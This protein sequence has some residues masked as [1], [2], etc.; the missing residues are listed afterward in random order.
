[1]KHALPL[2]AFFLFGALFSACQSDPVAKIPAL[3][4]ILATTN[5]PGLADT[6]IQLY[7]A[8][9]KVHPAKAA[10]NLHYLTKAAELKFVFQKDELTAV[11]WLNTAIKD[12]GQGQNLTEPIGM[13][14][15]IGHDY[16]Y[17]KTPGLSQ[18]PDDIDEMQSNLLKYKSWIDSSL[19]RLEKE[20]G[21]PAVTDNAKAD[22]FIKIAE[23]YAALLEHDNPDKGV[24]LLLMA[25][26]LAKTT[27]NANKAIQLYYSVGEKMPNHPKAPTALFM[28]AFIYEN[29]LQ[30]MDKAK[31]T[32]EL[33]LKRY[34]NDPDYADDAQNALKYLGKSPEEVVRQFEQNPQ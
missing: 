28:E 6:L 24:D 10:D 26:A 33:F 32:Y 2:A 25:G 20:M 5:S 13:L 21:S 9:V 22:I 17:Q 29:D 8:A 31:A 1:M 16:L 19:V 7:Q 15:R 23:T 30:D 34:P 4:K 3:E 12:Y 27:G 14:T 18:N 11:R